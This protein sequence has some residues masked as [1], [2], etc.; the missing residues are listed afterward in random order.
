M[1]RPWSLAVVFALACTAGAGGAF[2]Q[3][4]PSAQNAPPAYDLK[5]HALVDLADLQEK[6]GALAQA[7]PADK[8]TWR[9]A[10]GVRSIS[11][12]FL[13]VAVANFSLPAMIGVP[14]A[15]GFKP[16]GYEKSTT[17]KARIIEQL[18]Q[19]FDFARAGIEKLSNADLEKPVNVRWP[20]DRTAGDVL[21]H[22]ATHGHEHLGQSISYARSIGVVPPWTA[23]RQQSQQ[24]Q[25]APP[26]PPQE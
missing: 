20:I 1:N 24:G 17:D 21:F 19:S 8:Y 12:V 4:A 3:A 16:Q 18:N 22:L 14:P 2:G 15:R 5:S 10:D 26:R 6:F 7:I 9:P 23:A 13:H 11:E 25:Q